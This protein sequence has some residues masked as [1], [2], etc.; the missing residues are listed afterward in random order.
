MLGRGRWLVMVLAVVAIGG[1][2]VC[3]PARAGIVTRAQSTPVQRPGL[4]AAERQA[5]TIRSVTA[6]SDPS[7][8]LIVT[9]T[10]AG[11]I[12]RYLG[13]G[14]LRDGLVA[15][16][17][18][19]G[20]VMQTPGGLVAEGGGFTP[21]PFTILA[22]QGK[23]LTVKRGSTG[24]FGAERVLRTFSGGQYGVIRGGDQVIF[25]VAGPVLAEV[26]AIRVKV[27]VKCPLGVPKAGQTLTG[28]GWRAIVNERPAAVAAL[29]IDASLL[30]NAQLG[31]VGVALSGAA[32][33]ELRSEQKVRSQLMTAITQYAT[34]QRLIAGRGGFP[35]VT[36]GAL[37]SE[38]GNAVARI[39]R[40]RNEVGALDTLSREIATLSTPGVQVVQT[41]PGL[42][43]ELAAQP[44]R[45]IS[46]LQPQGLPVIDVNPQVRYQQF[47]G[48]GAAMT[49]SSAWLIYDELSPASRLALL[50]AL[51][52]APGLQNSLG[53]PAIHLNFLRVGIGAPGAMTVGAPYSYDDQPPGRSDPTLSDFS[54]SHDLPYI[55]PTLLQAL[56]VNPGL[57]IFANPWSPPGWM[58]SN[59]ALGNPNANATLLPSDYGPFATYIVK[60]IHAYQSQGVPIAAIAPA[61]EPSSG[62]VATNYPGMTFPEPEQA[63]FVAQNLAPALQAAGLHPKLY[64]NDLSW[65]STSYAGALASGPAAGD[66]SGISWHCYFGSPNAMTAQHQATPSLDQLVDECS[67]E[68][69]GFGT[70]EFLISSLRNWA[71]AVS[72]WSVALDPSGGPIQP[73]N[74]CPGCM[75]PVTINEQTQT[76]TLRPEYY[77]L[78]QVSSFI[79]PGAVRIDSPDFVTYGLNSSN[80]ETVSAGLDDVAFQNPDG[81]IVLVADNNSSAPVTFAVDSGGRY[82]TYTLPGYAMTTFVWR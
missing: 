47:T 17:L 2:A 23:R 25:R 69:R 14:D 42:T 7:L 32:G 50:Q 79:Q 62:Q 56:S 13:Q 28:A 8:G 58:K 77:Q 63:Q 24:M 21:A 38:L 54:I 4:T 75:G 1:A 22:R 16:V 76:V 3:G 43:E 64:G 34:V 80:I 9:V 55:V 35:R 51:F 52:G 26:A 12:E 82:F 27:F 10:F 67:P 30:S 31:T 19:P 73:G 65:D 41:D 78:G 68:I 36:R 81:S 53:I 46:T 48:V 44:G 11:D 5:I 15:L 61:N 72:V 74:D 37:I 57:E 71:S 33:P 40:L 60:F 45:A 29:T 6:A 70:P 49:D 39:G 20:T 18:E 59:G 66:L